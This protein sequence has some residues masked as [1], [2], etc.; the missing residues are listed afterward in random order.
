MLLGGT[1]MGALVPPFLEGLGI[2][3]DIILQKVQ[4]HY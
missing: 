2:V 3:N 4:L 1:A